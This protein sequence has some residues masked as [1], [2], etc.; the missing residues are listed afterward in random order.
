MNTKEMAINVA[1]VKEIAVRA[2][3]DEKKTNIIIASDTRETSVFVLPGLSK[4]EA[5]DLLQDALLSLDEGCGTST[6]VGRRDN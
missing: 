2:F 4:E 6:D 5:R 3:I 1:W